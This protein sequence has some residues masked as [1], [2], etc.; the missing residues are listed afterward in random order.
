MDKLL[1]ANQ[2]SIFNIANEYGIEFMCGP[3]TKEGF[4]DDSTPGGTDKK[5]A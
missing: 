1:Y 4:F 2:I 5:Y 3:E